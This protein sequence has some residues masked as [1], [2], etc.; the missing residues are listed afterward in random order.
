L[1]LAKS[2]GVYSV[3]IQPGAEDDAV[4]EFIEADAQFKARCIYREHSMHTST[5]PMMKLEG[6]VVLTTGPCLFKEPPVSPAAPVTLAAPLSTAAAL[7]VSNVVAGVKHV[8]SPPSTPPAAKSLKL[9]P[10]A[11][12]SHITDLAEEIPGL[13]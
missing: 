7:A 5:S 12:N 3:W 10:D 8:L 9:S 11:E 13:A 4:V 2:L 6:P 1:K